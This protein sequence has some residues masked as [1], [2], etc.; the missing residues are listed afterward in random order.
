MR[1]TLR[2]QW[3]P[4]SDYQS[5]EITSGGS[6][7]SP[8]S[9]AQESSK[10]VIQSGSGKVEGFNGQNGGTGTKGEAPKPKETSNTEKPGKP[11]EATSMSLD[12]SRVA[13]LLETRPLP[14]L[15]ALLA[16]FISVLPQPWVFRFVGSQEA[17]VLITSSSLSSHIK[18]GKL[19][20]DEL[21]SKYDIKTQESISMT[22]TDLAFYKDFLAP[23]EWLLMFQSDSI[24]CAAS[25]QSIEDYVSANYSWVGAPW[26][27]QV[28]GGNGGLSLRHV[29][30]ILKI[31]EKETREPGSV[32]EDRW[33]CDRLMTMEE[34]NM[35]GPDV[36]VRFSVESQWT[37]KP[38]GYHLMGSGKVMIEDI[39]GNEERRKHIMEYCPE[40]KIVLD[41]ELLWQVKKLEE[42]L[43]KLKEKD[44]KD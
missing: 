6:T 34:A 25:E 21:P 9:S 31:L 28:K 30:T 32:W 11:I 5:S 3:P 35:P 19:V 29:P 4:Q 27:M 39:W 37:E 20:V 24:I 8:I 38:F 18:T 26:N 13:L 42:E 22:L 1:T 7:T 10:P 40:V 12:P 14:H 2:Y 41:M 33:I 44:K 17:N 16:H 43:K 15:P 23:A 36:E